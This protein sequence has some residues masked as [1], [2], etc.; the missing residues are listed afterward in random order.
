MRRTG[1]PIEDNQRLA[2]IDAAR[3]LAIL[4]IFMVN[5][6][7]F[8]AP[9]FLYGG[10]E[11]YWSL[12]VD[13]AV[14]TIIDIFFQAS[15][16]TL[17]SFLFGFGFQ[18]MRE[19]LEAKQLNVHYIL[20]R[21]MMVLIGFGLIHSF[22]I[23]HGDILLSYG[24]IGL[25]LFFF[26]RRKN[27]TLISWSIAMLI[28]PAL[29]LTGLYY[30]VRDQLDNLAQNT[31]RQVN[32]SFANYGN[33]SLL[34]I[35]QQ[36]AGDWLYAN[37]GITYLFLIC[38]LLPLFLLGIY[39]ARKKWL[40]HVGKHKRLLAKAWIVTGLL[41]MLVKA[42]PYLI[43]NPMWLGSLQDIIGGSSSALFYLLSLT[44]A[45]QQTALR[46]LLEPLTSVG[47]MSLTNYLLQSIICFF[48]FYSVGFGF[49]GSIRPIHSAI[50]VL[51]IFSLQVILSKWWFQHYRFGPVEWL[52]RSLTYGRRQSFKKANERSGFPGRK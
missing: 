8:N 21:R 50:L 5:V 9:F 52:W 24:L 16:Y 1:G 49:Y 42:G 11:Q 13:H 26:Y 12:P 48:L 4:G 20:L 36:N 43:G 28:I 27:S 39:T 37:G 31:S 51:V 29:L 15:F 17:F 44:L 40:Y 22:L 30:L 32:Q 3:G 34:D 33:G 23:W 10:E 45:F 14:Q 19:R 38:N 41:F 47:R 18:L 7:A 46:K 35:W 25:L 6:P 2:W